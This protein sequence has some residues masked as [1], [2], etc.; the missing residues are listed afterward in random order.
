VKSPAELA[1]GFGRGLS[2]P[3][4]LYLTILAL[5]VSCLASKPAPLPEPVA[6]PDL[7][8]WLDAEDIEGRGDASRQPAQGEAIAAWADKSSYR[9]H[10]RQSVAPQQP[11]YLRD[12]LD[13]ELYAVHFQAAQ[14]QHV[15]AGNSPSLDLSLLTA[16]VVARA[17][18]P[19]S[20]MWMFS[21]NHWGPPWTGYGIAISK[22]GLRPWPHLGLDTGAHGYFQF[23][24]DL[25]SRFRV[26]ELCYDGKIARDRLEAAADQAQAVS[27]LIDFAMSG[28][29]H[30]V[31]VDSARLL[32][33][34]AWVD[35]NCPF[36][37]EEEVRV[38]ADPEFSGIE[39]LPIRPRLKTAPV[40]ERP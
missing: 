24:G 21:K 14:R 13:G 6:G 12:A 37:G 34:I 29:H 8:L 9:N 4:S 31:K 38:L 33:L 3:T 5:W 10:A 39:K 23:R 28:K 17:N 27:P 26:V 40:I 35:A 15:S 11:T 2:R 25:D 32:R 36:L 19:G 7:V 1:G 30:N 16:F 22:D 20:D 18:R